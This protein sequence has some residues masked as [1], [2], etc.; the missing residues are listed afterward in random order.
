MLI[1]ALFSNKMVMGALLV[2]LAVGLTG[3]VIVP[4]RW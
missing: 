2:P 1:V 3:E 4:Q